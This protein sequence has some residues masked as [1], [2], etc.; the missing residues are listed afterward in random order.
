MGAQ[1]RVCACVCERAHVHQQRSLDVGQRWQ[2]PEGVV[3]EQ[4]ESG[5]FLRLWSGF[6]ALPFQG[7][8]ASSC[9]WR[10][11]GADSAS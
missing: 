2:A 4:G 8:S 5:E 9:F 11:T 10:H 6:N 7:S 1:E 3:P